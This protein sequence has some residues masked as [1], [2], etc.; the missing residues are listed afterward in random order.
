MQFLRSLALAG[1]FLGAG[2]A[3]C[4]GNIAYIAS[5]SGYLL[6]MSNASAVTADWRGQAPIQG[7]TGYG[8]IQMNGRCLAGHSGGQPLTWE[9]CN[10]D[11]S[12]RWS[13]SG[14]RL[15][16]E[17]GWCADVEGARSGANVRVLA[18]QCSGA[19]NQQWRALGLE[20]AQS[21]AG[22]ISNAAV[23]STF[24]QTAAS[25]PAG[26]IISLASGRAVAAGGANVITS[27][28]ANVIAAGGGN[29][30]TIG[31]GN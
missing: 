22:R 21:A 23:R 15:R 28:G 31:G 6:H 4:A 19:A 30:I 16:N 9:N 13:L 1:A 26:S 11:R 18:Y 8:A 20:P 10:S 7:F 2:T 14:G 27:G 25:A 17:G 5:S 12:Q 24:L 29:V 3:A